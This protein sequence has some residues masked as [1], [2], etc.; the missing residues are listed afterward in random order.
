MRIRWI[1]TV[2]LVAMCATFAEAQGDPVE[3]LGRGDANNDGHVDISDALFLSTYLYE[4]SPEPSCKDQADVDDNGTVQGSDVTYLLNWL[5]NGGVEPPFPG[6][7]NTSCKKDTTTPNL[8]CEEN[9][10]SL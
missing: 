1:L 9:C 7:D 10:T 6:P 8:G 5:Y 3:I 2:S 4:G